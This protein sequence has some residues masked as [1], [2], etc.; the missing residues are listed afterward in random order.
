MSLKDLFKNL[1]S[2]IISSGSADKI[3]QE[4]ESAD[5]I[6]TY[7]RLKDKLRTHTDFSKPENFAKFGSAEKYYIDAIERIYKTFPYDGS[8]EEKIQWELSSSGIDLYMFDKEYPRTNGFANFVVSPATAGAEGTYY[9]PSSGVDEY[10]LIKGGPNT[11][12]RKKNKDVDDISGDYKDG[13]AN[14]YDL[15][16]NRENNLKIDGTDGNT[17]E[18]WLK[19]DAYVAPHQ[20]YYEFV[21]DAHVTGTVSTDMSYG[22]LAVVLATTGTTGNSSGQPFALIYASGTTSFSAFLGSSTLTTG[23]IA[24]GAWHHY[25]VRMKTSGSDTVVDLF[26]DGQHNDS[27]TQS[28]KAISYVSGNIVATVGAMAA[29]NNDGSADRGE[30][31]WAK[32]SGSL[33]EV[34]F[35]KTWRTAEQIGRQYIEPVG[36]GANT[37]TANTDLG[38]YYKFNEGITLTS[39]VDSTVLDYSG[40]I[41]NGVWTGYDS[42]QSR[43]T[44]SAIVLSGE[45]STEFKDPILYSFHPD[46]EDLLTKK[47]NIGKEYDYRNP[48]SIYNSIPSWVTETDNTNSN[49]PLK[50]LTQIIANYFDTLSNEIENLT[51]LKEVSY[52]SGTLSNFEKPYFFN[53]RMLQGAGFPHI[54]ELF[55]DASFF[56]FF[57][58]RSNTQ[59]FQEKLYDVKNTIYRNIYNNL[60]YINKSKGTEKAFRNMLRCFGVDDEIYKIRYYATDAV[61]EFRDNYKAIVENKNYVN[62][63]ITGSGGATVYQYQTDSN[64]TSYIT[65]SNAATGLEA[66]GFAFSVESQAVFPS[67]GTEAEYNSIIKSKDRSKRYRTNDF[68]TDKEGSLFGTRTVDIN[69]SENDLTVPTNDRAGFVVKVVRDNSY[70]KRA[71]FA[72]EPTDATS[73]FPTIKTS[74]FEDVFDDTKWN[75]AVVVK[76]TNY[77]Q[78]DLASGSI[79]NATYDVVFYGVNSA[80]EDV[81]NSFAVSS[82]ISRTYGTTILT[83]PKRVFAGA[84]RDNVSGSLVTRS[85]A[86]ITDC[87]FWLSPLSFDEVKRHNFDFENYGV[88]KP[89]QSAYLFQSSGSLT[90][91][92]KIET[93][94]LHWDFSN[95]TGSD[96]SGQFSVSDISSGSATDGR[97]N[98]LSKILSRQHSGRGDHFLESSTKSF[99][100][101][102][103]YNARTQLPEYINSSDM[104]SIRDQD[105]V[106]FTRSTRPT[107]YLVTFEKSM[108]QTVSEEMIKFFS[109]VADYGGMVGDPINEYR[110][111]YKHLGKLRQL[112][113]ENVDN[114]P[115]IEKYVD[116]YKWLDSG[117]NVM[118]AN[119]MPA[120]AVTFDNEDLIRPIIEEHIFNRNKYDHKFPTLEF[121]QTDPTGH[122]LGIREG[123]YNYRFGSA[124][125]PVIANDGQ[126]T[127]CLWWKVRAER[128][129]SG[130]GDAYVDL[131]RKSLLE[132]RN[133]QNNAAAP[134]LANSSGVAYS[135]STYAIRN[136]ARPYKYTVQLDPIIKGGTNFSRNKNLDLIN[137]LLRIFSS[138]RSGIDVREP[139]S[140]SFVCTDGDDLVSKKSVNS[141]ADVT[142]RAQQLSASYLSSSVGHFAA[143]FNLVSGSHGAGH[144]E[145]SRVVNLHND[146]YGYDKE[147]PAQGPFTER[148]VGGKQYRHTDLNTGSDNILDRAEGFHIS[149]SYRDFTIFDP[150]HDTHKVFNAH[151]PRATL[152][153]EETAKRPVNIK[154]IRHTT[155]SQTLGNFSNNYEVVLTNGRKENNKYLVS[156]G[157]DLETASVDSYYFSGAI[158]FSLPVRTTNKSIIVNKFS[159]PGD[160][161]TMGA[162]YLDVVSGEYSIYNAL[163][164]RNLNVRMP[165]QELLTNHCDEGG[166]YSDWFRLQTYEQAGVTYPGGTGSINPLDYTGTGSFHKTPMNPRSQLRYSTEHVG[167]EGIVNNTSSQ[168]NYFVRH[169]IPQTDVQYA[170][171][172]SSII[173]DY[174]GPALYGFE[175]RDFSNASYASTDLT[176][177]SSSVDNFP[178]GTHNVP[179]DFVS[180]RTI[181]LDDVHIT[182][183]LNLLSRSGSSGPTAYF[184]LGG[185]GNHGITSSANEDT[186]NLNYI[187]L[188]RGGPYGGSNWKLYKK[189]AHP[190][191]RTFKKQNRI[192]FITSSIGIDRTTGH[193]KVLTGVTSSIE[194]AINSKHKPITFNLDIQTSPDGGETTVTLNQSYMNN[195]VKFSEKIGSLIDLNTSNAFYFIENY[196]EQKLAY[197]TLTTLITDE[198]IAQET[199][200]INKVNFIT[201]KETIYPREKNTYLKTTRQRTAFRNNFW[202][203]DRTDRTN[204]GLPRPFLENIVPI[205]AYPASVWPLDARGDWLSE[206]AAADAYPKTPSSTT[207]Q[208]GNEGTL[209]FNSAQFKAGVADTNKAAGYICPIY[210]R[211][212]IEYNNAFYVVGD[213]KWEAGEQA[214]VNPFY[215]SYDDY[216][217]EIKRMGKDFGII[218][219]FRIS[220]HMDYYINQKG[221]DFLAENTASLSLTGAVFDNQSDDDFAVNYSHSDFLKAFKMVN[222][223]YKDKVPATRLEFECEGLLKFLPYNDFY[224]AQRTVE[225]SRMFFEDYGNHI[226]ANN[227]IQAPASAAGLGL[228]ARPIFQ[229]L[230]S[231][232]IL[233]NSIKSGI[234]VDYPVFTSPFVSIGTASLRNTSDGFM[235]EIPRISSSFDERIPFEVLV[236]PEATLIGMPLHDQEPHPDAH[237]NITASLLGSSRQTYKL[238]MN[239][240]LASTIDFFKPDG[241]LSTLASLPDNNGNFGNFKRGQKYIMDITL[242]HSK[243]RSYQQIANFFSNSKGGNAD[244]YASGSYNL[245][246][247]TIVMYQRTGSYDTY[248]SSFGPPCDNSG[249]HLSSV[250]QGTTGGSGSIDLIK[251]ELLHT[252]AS[253]EAYTAPYYNGY[254]RIRVEFNPTRTD[255]FAVDEIV[256]QLTSSFLRFCLDNKTYNNNRSQMELSA[257]LNY[258]Q[259]SRQFGVKFDPVGNPIE[260]DTNVQ[261]NQMV[262]QPKWET[263]VLDFKNASFTEPLRGSGSIAQGM[264]HQYGEVPAGSSQGIFMQ[265]Q[266]SEDRTHFSLA[267]EMGFKK[268]PVRVGEIAQE[269]EIFEA[270]V[271]IPHILRTPNNE[272]GVK[273][274]FTIPRSTI[275]IAEKIL[276]EGGI[277]PQTEN[278]INSVGP[279]NKPT[280]DIVNMVEKMKKYVFPPRLDF[281]T[282]KTIKPFA[283][284]IFEFSA[285]LTQADLSKIWQNLMPDLGV[286]AKKSKASLPVNIF[287]SNETNGQALLDTLPDNIQWSVFKVKQ[288]GAF[289]YFTKTADSKDDVRFKFNF[290]VGGAGAEKESVP[291]YSYNWPYDYFSLVE[292]A[293]IDCKVDFGKP[294][295]LESFPKVIPDP[296]TPTIQNYP[297]QVTLEGIRN[298]TTPII[299]PGR[300]V[301][302]LLAGIPENRLTIMT[303]TAPTP[304]DI[305]A[306]TT[307]AT[308]TSA[309]LFPPGLSSNTLL[310]VASDVDATGAS[311]TS[312]S[313]IDLTARPGQ[314]SDDDGGG[315]P[316]PPLGGNLFGGGTT[317]Y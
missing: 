166:Y 196:P 28:S 79:Y 94:A 12:S 292:L 210:N 227:L 291:D 228:I 121:K 285:T 260:V 308:M 278:F 50:N 189:D 149:G 229:P 199:N 72:V 91:V 301:R 71:Y 246:P 150:A 237:L 169:Q 205:S 163:P 231:P 14:T 85:N 162:G 263:P 24:D 59:L 17:V 29:A 256:P 45:A 22:R 56:E 23:S 154:N 226:F 89:Y 7:S 139:E 157:G 294:F 138:G 104:V 81:R 36:A 147:V 49:P 41:S 252:S 130:S 19:K 26:V 65:A 16:N 120:T 48:N 186:I 183:S 221:G 97:F 106:T 266:D 100:K 201:T 281:I 152:Y 293:K 43:S 306:L 182:G 279:E 271:A 259:I 273:T 207:R 124:P 3:A 39:S 275:D 160:P 212:I 179:L 90:R 122:L 51:K 156:S 200:P 151:L 119:L 40:R 155:A 69:A 307:A 80:L 270:I 125:P 1:N 63:A 165:L 265:I 175:K 25:A 86:F 34:R 254:A 239:N 224:P 218:P 129:L 110:S 177:I 158:D 5:Y 148:H 225:L 258:L 54:P 76:P 108:Y 288:R 305:R 219:E 230:F 214:G 144:F 111:E 55:S 20:Q 44:G 68:I 113:F 57:R 61:H 264:W 46:V 316:A 178:G 236:E 88:E 249:S 213:T 42:T 245:N 75:F 174:A 300:D 317:N 203:D 38:V 240:F 180:L 146:T 184:N 235:Q 170:W 73:Y 141:T 95:L 140:A 206:G 286:S 188:N 132:I 126:E 135:G 313:G 87:R 262:I 115:K 204:D 2:S 159:A 4:V 284:F 277:S 107:S 299:T 137:P 268:S 302:G 250:T 211:R 242:G 131:D 190:V 216:A 142:T 127:D 185:I 274:R 297:T 309:P 223:D 209:Q 197:N 8:L 257:S 234:A 83:S 92:P 118:L 143:P 31:G 296:I 117:L 164:W 47:K 202:R 53:D 171:I 315:S 13:Y 10:I 238:A 176:F 181:V 78:Y 21:F 112:F 168:D 161:S 289:N 35:W 287:E 248:G 84:L 62:F 194:P 167:E 102:S 220:E 114:T 74:Y 33:D 217:D 109:S 314:G 261:T 193:Q 66:S 82:S 103:V 222:Q 11:S 99:E 255:K 136:F 98:N 295:R 15:S 304:A 290:E 67:I 123:L 312:V 105:D 32:F 272:N 253:Y 247:P 195:F 60:V 208:Q 251:N 70:D 276:L 280:K 93:L 311:L 58:N 128:D 52:I 303:Q 232:G 192:S 153:R 116:Y 243:A 241:R 282:N 77:G 187:I 9:Y 101:K 198:S 298:Q 134:S 233:Y 18:F 6:E 30:R 37:D 310:S 244:N 191:V 269:K 96:T 64:T 27:H 267:D 172:K 145:F 133:N 173:N 215:D 283:M